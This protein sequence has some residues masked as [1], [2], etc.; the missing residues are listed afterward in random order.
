MPRKL[1]TNADFRASERKKEERNRRKTQ[2]RAATTQTYT[3]RVR[4]ESELELAT[5]KAAADAGIQ[6]GTYLR[7]ALIEKLQ[8]D[9]YIAETPEAPEE[10]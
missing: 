6:P 8:R 5:E 9:G 4:H 10:E 7:L 3:V 2:K 1:I